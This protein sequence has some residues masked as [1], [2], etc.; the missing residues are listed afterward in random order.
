VKKARDADM[1]RC[2]E[3]LAVSGAYLTVESLLRK[4]GPDD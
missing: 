1:R 2:A 3:K 4:L